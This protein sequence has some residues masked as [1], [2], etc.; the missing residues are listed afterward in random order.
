M[1][2]KRFKIDKLIRDN[3]PEVMRKLGIRVHEQIMD[4]KEYIK[5]L[6]DKLLEEVH[7]I[8]AAA[9]GED[10]LEELADGIEVIQS[11]AEANGFSLEQVEEC[12]RKKRQLK[13]GFNQKIFC[14][15]ID[16]DENNEAINEYIDSPEK[17]PEITELPHKPQP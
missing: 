7:E 11:L 12:R 5:S 1:A 13:G 9:P 4:E 3:L 10:L 8:I 17:Y 16:I 2:H 14:Q 6:K 15:Y